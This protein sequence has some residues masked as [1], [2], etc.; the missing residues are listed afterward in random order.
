MNEEMFDERRETSGW[1]EG[2][3]D[4]ADPDEK[5]LMTKFRFVRHKKMFF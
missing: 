2:A 4:Y 1:P 3:Q 5:K